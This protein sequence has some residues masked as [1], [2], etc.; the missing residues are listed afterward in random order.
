MHF[1][2]EGQLEDQTC[3]NLPRRRKEENGGWQFPVPR[4]GSQA[5]QKKM[6]WCHSPLCDCLGKGRWG[7]G[8]EGKRHREEKY[9]YFGSKRRNGRTFWLVEL[10]L[11]CT[12]TFCRE[13][14]NLANFSPVNLANQPNQSKWRIFLEGCQSGD[15]A[16]VD[17]VANF[18]VV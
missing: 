9:T 17:K 16:K 1:Q 11:R 6:G 7:W 5:Q 3:L 4:E 2:K 8:G 15:R 12:S 13:W 18:G 10:D 14:V